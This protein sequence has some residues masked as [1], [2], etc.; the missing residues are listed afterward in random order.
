MDMMQI[1]DQGGAAHKKAAVPQNI[2]HHVRKAGSNGIAFND[3]AVCQMI[4]DVQ[5]VNIK[6]A[7]ALGIFQQI[8]AVFVDSQI[9]EPD[10]LAMYSLISCAASTQGRIVVV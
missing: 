1:Y 5:N 8:G 6:A 2:L 3:P 10:T 7:G 4:V 9:K